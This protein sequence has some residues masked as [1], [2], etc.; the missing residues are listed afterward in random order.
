MTRY[1]DSFAFC[2]IACLWGLSLAVVEVGLRT[3]PPL[4]LSAFRYYL[5]GVLLLGYVGATD[6]EWLPSTRGDLLAVAGGGVFWIA[7]GNGV[8]FVGQEITTSVL[9]GLMVS[10]T[11]VATAVVSWA[12][13]PEDRLTPAAFVGLVVSFA[14]ATLMLW[15]T[16][17][18]TAA[19]S[20]LGKAILSVGVLGLGVGSVLLRA[21]PTSLPT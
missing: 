20:V 12:L 14:G 11:P 18:I 4:L 21:A 19:G 15:P 8:W 3:F 1:R 5:A 13:L 10:L 6:D 16:G 7:V 9:S 2:T 17:G